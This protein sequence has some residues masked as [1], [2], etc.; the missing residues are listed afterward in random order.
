MYI[1]FGE[2]W[3]H[4][5]RKLIIFGILVILL[6]MTATNTV[7]YWGYHHHHWGHHHWGGWSGGGWN[8]GGWGWDY[9][10]YCHRQC[11]RTWRWWID[12]WGDRHWRWNRHCW[13]EYY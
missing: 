4:M 5:N 11:E 2:N 7:A 13:C 10:P 12:S 3:E 6:S 1:N 9:E 8:D